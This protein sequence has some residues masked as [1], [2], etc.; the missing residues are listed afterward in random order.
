MKHSTFQITA[1]PSLTPTGSPTQG[2]M[3]GY[4]DVYKPHQS[5]V[6]DVNFHTE[7]QEQIGTLSTQMNNKAL[8]SFVQ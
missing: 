3:C 1:R 6:H 4:T 7:S 5:L 2:L 8:L